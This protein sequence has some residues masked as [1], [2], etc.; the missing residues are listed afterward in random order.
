VSLPP[1]IIFDLDGVVVDSREAVEMAYRS[2]GTVMPEDAWGKPWSE[3]L[4]GA[5]ATQI[6]ANKCRVYPQML[7][8]YALALPLMFY[9]QEHRIPIITGASR[10][11]AR[12][13]NVTFGVQ[14]NVIEWSCT[15]EKKVSVLKF[16]QN[17]GQLGIYVDDDEEACQEISE[18]TAWRATTPRL[19]CQNVLNEPTWARQYDR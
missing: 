4:T 11:A 18:R 3:W 19:F 9:A 6:H 16:L 8:D 15:R 5:D 1:A 10:E 12:S 13:V 14:L 7:R 2:A 17:T